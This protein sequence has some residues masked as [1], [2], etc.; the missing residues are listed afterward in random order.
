MVLIR[1]ARRLFSSFLL[2]P[3]TGSTS[4]NS[5]YGEGKAKGGKT[6]NDGQSHD[7]D[8]VVH[9]ASQKAVARFLELLAAR[10][11]GEH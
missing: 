9:S 4:L 2:G 10:R 1:S 7:G 8:Q 11:Q 6:M 5:V 3:E